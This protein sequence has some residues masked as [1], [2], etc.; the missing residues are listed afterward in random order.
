MICRGFFEDQRHLSSHFEYITDC[1]SLAEN[2]QKNIAP[3]L[4]DMKLY[5]SNVDNSVQFNDEVWYVNWNLM[6]LQP[7]ETYTYW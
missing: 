6:A 3:F 5:L 4:A 1:P 2:I 7:S